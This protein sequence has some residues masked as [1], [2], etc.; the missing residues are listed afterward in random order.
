[1]RSSAGARAAPCASAGAAGHLHDVADRRVRAVR[2]HHHPVGEQDRLVD[3][4]SDADR[5][6]LGARPD[7][8]QHV[9][10]LPAGEAVEHAEWLVEQQQ[11]GREREGAGDA[12][13]LLHAVR[14]LGGAPV[15]GVAEADA[16]EVVLDD[17]A[18]LGRRRLGIDAVDAE[19]DVLARRQP[20]HQ[21]RRLE[22]DGPVRPGAAD[23]AGH[24]ARCRR[25][26]SR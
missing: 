4:V 23:L 14:E 17:V 7:L 24:R 21:R 15:H 19:R 10:Q 22:D 5:G 13:A 2:H 12:D 16:V 25:S 26:R 6:D 1:M 11:L 8:H 18:P 20:R 9:L 3:V